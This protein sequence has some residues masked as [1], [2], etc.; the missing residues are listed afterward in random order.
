METM[1]RLTSEISYTAEETPRGAQVRITTRNAEAIKAIHQF[2]RF[3]IKEHR[4][5]DP[6]EV[7]KLK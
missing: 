1:K 5:G 3:Q 6:L 7:T 4:T 2:L